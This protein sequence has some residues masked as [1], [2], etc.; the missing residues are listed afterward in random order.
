MS[1]LLEKAG[2]LDSELKLFK[3]SKEAKLAQLQ[4]ASGSKSKRGEMRWKDPW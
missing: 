2:Q 4:A 3:T 1:K